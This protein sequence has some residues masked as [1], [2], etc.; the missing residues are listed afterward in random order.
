[1]SRLEY[2]DVPVDILAAVRVRAM[3]LPEVAEEQ[4]WAG[5]RWRGPTERSPAAR[6]RLRS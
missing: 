1:M 5:R 2:A 6:P 3:V 4:A